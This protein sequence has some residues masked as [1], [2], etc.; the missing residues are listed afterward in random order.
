MKVILIDDE[1]LALDYLEHQLLQVAEVEIIGKFMDPLLGQQHVLQEQADLVFL[2]IHLPEINGIE[3]A[4][5]LLE[6]KPNLNIVF[7]TAYD[8]Y[9]VKAFELNA[10]DYVVKPVG[11]ERLAKTLQRL[12]GNVNFRGDAKLTDSQSIRMT[13]LQHVLIETSKDRLTPLHWRTTKA[14]E[15]FLFLLQHRGSLVRKSVLIET[16]WPDYETN[17][18]YAQLY[19]SIYHIRKTLEPFG[20]RFQISNM[21]DGYILNAHDVTLDVEEWEHKLKSAPPVSFETIE[22]YHEIMQL[23]TGH[24]LR[25]YGFWWAESE[26]QRLK[27]LWMRAAFQMA[28][29]YESC[30]KWEAAAEMYFQITERHPLAEEAHFALMNIFAATNNHLAVTRQYRLLTNVLLEELNELPSPY[31][32]E[33]YD[34]LKLDNKG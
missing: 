21:T 34:R 31:I 6:K 7:V 8:E 22:Y 16:L 11:T 26:R 25:E 14:H 12:Q 19:T 5:Q 17:K 20:G 24:Y 30:G 13:V 10:L 33:W 27:T 1:R 3:L 29:W 2:D 18:V 15:L 28:E 23:Y 9:A 4:E 32:T